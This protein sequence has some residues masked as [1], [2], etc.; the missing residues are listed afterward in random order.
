M[1]LNFFEWD[2]FDIG[3]CDLINFVE[4]GV[5]KVCC[6]KYWQKF[7]FNYMFIDC[8]VGI[9]DFIEVVGEFFEV[10]VKKYNFYLKYG[11]FL[12]FFINF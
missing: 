2:D 10:E 12:F 4:K 1:V 8:C 6:G 9:W 7:N 11:I 3:F 5:I